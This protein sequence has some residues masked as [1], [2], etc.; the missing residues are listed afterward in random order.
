MNL[1]EIIAKVGTLD[2]NKAVLTDEPMQRVGSTGLATDD[3]KL[4]AN[5]AKALKIAEAA[6]FSIGINPRS[7]IGCAYCVRYIEKS[8]LAL[9]AISRIKEGRV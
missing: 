7:V 3:L 8:K 1:D 9:Q 5:H 2:A 4:L 6:L